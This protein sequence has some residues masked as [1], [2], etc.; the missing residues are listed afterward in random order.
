MAKIH[1]GY[2]VEIK[3]PDVRPD[4]DDFG[5]QNEPGEIVATYK[6][7]GI[8]FE[9]EKPLELTLEYVHPGPSPALEKPQTPPE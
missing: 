8:T 9:D 2:T 5:A 7:I 6:V 3:L 4:P 1:R